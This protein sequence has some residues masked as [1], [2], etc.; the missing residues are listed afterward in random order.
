MAHYTIMV[1]AFQH[2]HL[3]IALGKKQAWPLQ[4]IGWDIKCH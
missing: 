2:G 3:V 1:L 4:D